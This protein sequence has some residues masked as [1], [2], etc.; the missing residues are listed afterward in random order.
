MY[1]QSNFTLRRFYYAFDNT[2]RF[3][4]LAFVINLSPLWAQNRLQAALDNFLAD[5]NLKNASVS[6]SLIDI[7]RGKLI[8]SHQPDLSLAPA[9][10]SKSL[11]LLLP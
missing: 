2:T 10:L 5:P 11:L 8:L 6:V 3:G 9:L 1:V 7:E 4:L